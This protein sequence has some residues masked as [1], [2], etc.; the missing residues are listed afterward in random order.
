MEAPTSFVD[1]TEYQLQ[2]SQAVVAN[3]RVR[4]TLKR[5][6]GR[7]RGLLPGSVTGELKAR[8]VGGSLYDCRLSDDSYLVNNLGLELQ[9]CYLLHCITDTF[10]PANGRPGDFRDDRSDQIYVYHLGTL[11][12]DGSKVIVAPLCY[13]P[14]TNQTVFEAMQQLD[15]DRWHG[16]W[17][18]RL[19]TFGQLG[20][21]SRAGGI[22]LRSERTALMLASTIGE[23]DPQQHETGYGWE[24]NW[25]PDRLR[26]LDLR[27]VLDQETAVLVG[28]ANDPGPVRL[29]TRRH[30]AG[31]DGRFRVVS[32]DQEASWT[33]YRIR[34]PVT[35]SGASNAWRRPATASDPADAE[36]TTEDERPEVEL[37]NDSP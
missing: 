20:G 14:K 12:S 11:P 18:S 3:V 1:P 31:G 32:P 2:P 30:T 13:R 6:A 15:L 37:G 4:A 35:M 16:E 10:T 21:R 24:R 33:M 36:Q 9:D 7:W 34:I 8:R 17:D 23:W 25:S 19:G 29:A 5:F 28:F 22:G 26:E 27:R